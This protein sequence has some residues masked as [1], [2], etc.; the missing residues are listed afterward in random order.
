ME[1]SHPLLDPRV[2]GL[3]LGIREQ[4]PMPAGVQKPLLREVFHEHLP[5]SIL[6]RNGKGNFDELYFRGL[7]D[8]RRALQQLIVGVSPMLEEWFHP[9]GLSQEL[10]RVALGGMAADQLRVFDS[11]LSL[12]GW[13]SQLD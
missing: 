3:G 9:G 6:E 5:Q 1:L 12:L 4:R 7:V 11:V 8:H 2:I 13:F 10:E